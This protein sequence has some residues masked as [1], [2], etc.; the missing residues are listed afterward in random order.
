V[1]PGIARRLGIP[2]QR[3]VYQHPVDNGNAEPF[4]RSLNVDKVWMTRIAA[5]KKRK[6][7][8]F[9][10]SRSTIT[11]GLI[12]GKIAPRMMPY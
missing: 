10:G 12:G 7:A 8:S 1:F 5:R 11:T 2:Y 9:A 4:H 6:P 3:T